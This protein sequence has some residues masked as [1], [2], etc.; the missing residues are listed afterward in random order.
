[1]ER[2]YAKSCEGKAQSITQYP[3]E[4][5]LTFRPK[6][7]WEKRA[8]QLERDWD[9]WLWS[10]FGDTVGRNWE[11]KY[12]GLLLLHSFDLVLLLSIGW[13]ARSPAD[14]V[15]SGQPPRAWSRLARGGQ[16]IC[17]GMWK[18]SSVG[19]TICFPVYLCMYI[20]ESSGF[21]FVVVF[22]FNI[23]GIISHASFSNLWFSLISVLVFSPWRY[24]KICLTLPC[25]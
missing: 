5:F 13:E 24:F 23:L 6:E 10:V 22:F 20:Y 12:S 3:R 16:W 19:L 1:M 8:K 17:R 9:L 25:A 18:I 15:H 4:G 7:T 21:V 2:P 11:N 14:A